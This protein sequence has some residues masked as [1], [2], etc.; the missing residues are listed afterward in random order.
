MQ[1]NDI[2]KMVAD[3]NLTSDLLWMMS[4][5]A[6]KYFLLKKITVMI[7]AATITI[8]RPEGI[9]TANNNAAIPALTAPPMLYMPWQV[10]IK[11]LLNFFSIRFTV[12]LAL[13]PFK[14]LTVPKQYRHAQNITRLTE[15]ICSIMMPHIIRYPV[16]IHLPTDILLKTL[17]DTSMP[18]I[19]PKGDNNKDSPSVPSLK[20]SLAFTPG[21]DATQI[22]NN[23]LEVANKNPTAKADLFFMK[24]EKFFSMI[25]IKGNYNTSAK[26]IMV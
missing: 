21:I 8:C 17:V 10:L 11:S 14:K 2:P 7:T 25:K 4:L 18:V 15:L 1:I 23:K 16:S 3:G 26:V 20:P 12:A 6:S 19:A 13:I 24:E 5:W 22:P 9:C